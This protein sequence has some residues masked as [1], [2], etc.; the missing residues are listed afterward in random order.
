MNIET[1]L[2]PFIDRSYQ[3]EKK[4]RPIE[5]IDPGLL[6]SFLVEVVSSIVSLRA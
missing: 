3:R 6:Q 5:V 4:W 1:F 2:L